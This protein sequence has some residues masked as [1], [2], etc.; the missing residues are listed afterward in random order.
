MEAMAILRMQVSKMNTGHLDSFHGIPLRCEVRAFSYSVPASPH[1]K[2]GE[3]D[4]SGP[5]TQMS[6]GSISNYGGTDLKAIIMH[7]AK[8]PCGPDSCL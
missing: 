4:S 6:A 5:S 7:L 3:Q 8:D 1:W 2:M